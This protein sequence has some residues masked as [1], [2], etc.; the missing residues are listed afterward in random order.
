MHTPMQMN[1]C[2]A[3]GMGTYHSLMR[4]RGVFLDSLWVPPPLAVFS[5]PFNSSAPL[6]MQMHAYAIEQLTHAHIIKVLHTT[7]TQ[8]CAGTDSSCVRY[9]H[10]V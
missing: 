9:T 10:I 2:T 3:A 4:S 8:S 5:Q 6:C 1:A 7:R